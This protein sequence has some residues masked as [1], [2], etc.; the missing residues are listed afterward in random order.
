MEVDTKATVTLAVVEATAAA[1]DLVVDR[2]HAAVAAAVAVAPVETGVLWDVNK[3]DP[4]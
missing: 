1:A 4:S 2:V 3:S